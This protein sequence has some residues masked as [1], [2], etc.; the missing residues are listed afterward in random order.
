[1]GW[2]QVGERFRYRHASGGG[3]GEQRHRSTLAHRHG[4][5]VIAVV[6]G[7]GDGAIGHRD[8]PGANHL[9]AIDQ[10]SHAAIANGD[11]EGLLR[12]GRQTQNPLGR[13]TQ[14]DAIELERFALCWEG[15]H[16][17]V[18][19]GRLAQQH[20]QRQIDGL[21]FKVAVREGQ[22][23]LFGRGT[24]DG[25]G[26]RSRSHRALNSGSLSCATAST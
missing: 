26:A 10:A 14:S 11:K 6:G 23:L 17:T 3:V 16:V 13:V 8:L 12:H 1:M 21:I 15:H 4:F 5:A 19:L 18:H 22:M 7:S 9:V 24:D 20:V 25:I 2:R